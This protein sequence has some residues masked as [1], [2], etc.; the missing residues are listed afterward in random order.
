MAVSNEQREEIEALRKIL[1]KEQRRPI[2]YGEAEEIG[3][4]LITFFELLADDSNTTSVLSGYGQ[5]RTSS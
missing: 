5:Q 3:E 1:A 4:S 2:P